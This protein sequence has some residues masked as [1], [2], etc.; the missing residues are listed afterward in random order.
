M[1]PTLELREVGWLFEATA[2]STLSLAS[3]AQR[4]GL[5]GNWQPLFRALLGQTRLT[6]GSAQ[7][8]GCDLGC[9]ISDGVLGFALC[10]PE[11]PPTFTVLEYLLHAARL[12]HGSRSRARQEAS[13]ALQRFELGALAKRE[14]S[15]LAPFERRAL[16]ILAATLTSPPV[17]LLEAPLRDL[18]APAADYVARLCAVASEHSRVIVSA[19]YPHSPSA[20]RALL[21]ACDELFVLEGGTLI[22]QG[23]PSTLFAPAQRYLITVKGSKIAAFAAALSG[24]GCTL[25]TRSPP[26]HFS[27]DLPLD[28]TTDL[29]LDTALAHDLIVLELEPLYARPA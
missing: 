11:L 21:D 22:A 17:V 16:G 13:A 19:P 6:R 20:E 18:E 25:D 28:A 10:D 8:F 15:R 12:T 4:V 2:S 24:A 1:T 5:V 7:F 23:P 26:G 29:L 9:A 3:H 14:L 27:V